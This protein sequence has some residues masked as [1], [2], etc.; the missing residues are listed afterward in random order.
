MSKS[1][2]RTRVVAAC[3]SAQSA[4][5]YSA[6]KRIAGRLPLAAQFSVVDDLI[7]CRRRLEGMGV[8]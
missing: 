3:A 4:E 6:A 5:D 8:L 2:L 7:S 1:C